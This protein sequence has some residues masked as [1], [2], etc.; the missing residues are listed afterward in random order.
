MFGKTSRLLLLSAVTL[1]INTSVLAKKTPQVKEAKDVTEVPAKLA[2]KN[3]VPHIGAY[4]DVY[5]GYGFAGWGKFTD[6]GH[7]AWAHIGNI[8]PSNRKRGA[9]NYGADL[10]Y[11][12]IRYLALEFGYFYVP[13]VKGDDLSI[14]TPYV[15]AAGK[16]S[17]PFLAND[18]LAIF[19]KLGMAYRLLD[20]AGGAQQ[21]SYQNKRYSINPLYGL[22][23]QY[24]LSQ[25]W[26]ASVQWLQIPSH[27]QGAANSKKSSKQ[28]PRTDQIV[29]GLGYSFSV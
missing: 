11:S 3:L 12:F 9:M 26:R 17:Y 20:Y 2:E 23:A 24:Y 25:Y 28:V 22:G 10:G 29:F 27:T 18:D 5:A 6:N 16:L 1:L 7:G 8:I 14:A 13:S 15:Y 21:G 4:F 19:A